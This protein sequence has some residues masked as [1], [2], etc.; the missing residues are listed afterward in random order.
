MRKVLSKSL[1]T[2]AATT[3]VLASAAGYAQADAGAGGGA[4]GSPGVLS[5]NAVQA[6]VHVPA[7]VCGNTVNVV[8]A[9]NPAFGNSCVNEPS[10]HHHTPPQHH[11]PEEEPKNPPQRTEEEPP[12][13]E[14]ST[15]EKP[16]EPAQE[17]RA[18]EAEKPAVQA[19]APVEEAAP[20]AAPEQE[21]KAPE[22]LAETGAEGPWGAA[23]L[24]LGALLG[25]T[26][27]YRRAARNRV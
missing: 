25:G 9:L 19:D 27:L 10:G 18:P 3:G 12:K 5:G 13:Q 26:V 24:G 4:A 21:E 20:V 16:A 15:P 22:M 2:A 8:G 17:P 7:N 1:L 11:E 6:P 23:A 14:E